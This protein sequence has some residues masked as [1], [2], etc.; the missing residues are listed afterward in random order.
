MLLVNCLTQYAKLIIFD[1]PPVRWHLQTN[2]RTFCVILICQW[3]RHL[4]SSKFNSFKLIKIV[5]FF[6][7]L[8][9][10]KKFLE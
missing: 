7:K 1:L 9:V 10:F 2:T 8:Y 6:K 4:L 5:L 3:N